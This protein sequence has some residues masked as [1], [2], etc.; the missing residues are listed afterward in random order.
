MVLHKIVKT[1]AYHRRLQVKYRRR[2]EGKTDYQARK[3]LIIQDQRTINTPKHRL[4][5]RIT[6]RDVIC[7]IVLAH[8]N[9]D[10]IM[11]SAYA[12][13]LPRYGIKV[14][15]TNY[16][17][18]YATGL[19]LARRLLQNLK[20][21]KVFQGVPEAN[22]QDKPLPKIKKGPRPFKA[23]LDVG[24]ARTTTGSRVFAAMK[25]ACDGGLN[26]PH[27]DKR[28]VG[29]K[30]KKLDANVLKEHIFGVHVAKYMKELKESDNAAYQK[31]FSQYLKEGITA[32]KVEKMYKDAHKA[33]R[34]D[35]SFHATEKKKPEKGSNALPYPKYHKAHMKKKSLKERKHL[36]ELKMAQIRKHAKSFKKAL[37]S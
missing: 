17:A 23:F 2:R 18:C 26:I 12:H 25:G 24:L 32:D 3:A 4:V 36:R 31:H 29:Y 11:C 5:V 30:N 28:L 21:D 7:Q 8:I 19:L 27:S 1:K 14:G 10:S 13:E 35:P 33:I 16:A 22:G 34:E 20:L 15:L 9:G 37:F 6:N